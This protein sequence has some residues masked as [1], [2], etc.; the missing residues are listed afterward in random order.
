[1]IRATL[2]LCLTVITHA[3]MTTGAFQAPADFSGTWAIE[4]SAA[5][6][7]TAAPQGRPDQ[8]QLAVGDM[9]SGWGSPIAITQDARQ[10]RVEQTLFS[11]YDANPQPQFVYALDGSE[12]RNAVMLG[13]T[14]QIRQ[15]RA[16]WE[17]QALRITTRYPAVD[18]STGTPQTTQVTHRLSLET[19]TRLVI[20]VVRHAA[21]GGKDTST[22]TAYRKN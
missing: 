19:P 17:G 21:F 10:L 8:G 18:P 5:A 3:A 16:V 20:E 1:M 9:G 2:A 6:L 13:H 15:S 12:T 11:R 22:R 7:S 14:T 4:T